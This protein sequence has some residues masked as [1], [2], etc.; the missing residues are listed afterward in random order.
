M[1]DIPVSGDVGPFLIQLF[2][3]M[4]LYHFS[5]DVRCVNSVPELAYMVRNIDL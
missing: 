4:L 3:A 5:R 2:L 1:P